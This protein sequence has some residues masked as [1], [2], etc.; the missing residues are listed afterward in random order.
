MRGTIMNLAGVRTLLLSLAVV[1]TAACERRELSDELDYTALIPVRI[2]WSASGL[3]MNEIHRASVW[4]FPEDNSAPL[5]YRLEGNLTYREIEIPVG[6][7]SVLAF[8]ETV[9]A[10]DW[11]AVTFTGTRRYETFAAMGVPETVRGFYTRSD[12]L[13]LIKNPEPLAA[14][15]LDRFEVTLEMVQRTRAVVRG[16]ET[17]GVRNPLEVEVPELTEVKPLPRFE[18]MTVT[19]RVDNLVSAM[20]ATGTIDGM[21]SGVYLV[22]G[23]KIPTV[24]A[25]AFI[26]SGRL[27]DGNGKDG[28]ITRTFNTFG[29]LPPSMGH[30]SLD[31]DFLLTDGTLH[32]RQNFNVKNLIITVPNTLIPTKSIT[33][34]YDL[35]QGD[36][37]VVLPSVDVNA[38]ITVNEW[39][40]V[41]I[42]LM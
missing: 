25:H 28:T 15:S 42:P 24:S 16:Q 9:D 5:E 1:L 26:L 11:D 4:F 40:E 34:G 19:A 32:P 2:D 3:S 18:R 17:P 22:S 29:C 8:N 39:E 37:P 30:N 20:Q 21:A 31:L 36:H 14:W 13:P 27:Y 41:V 10:G 38:G 23:E 12:A 7:Y 35:R 33:V 6:V